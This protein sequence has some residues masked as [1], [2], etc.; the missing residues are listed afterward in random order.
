[1][2]FME[3]ILHL[4]VPSPYPPLTPRVGR[5]NCLREG[6]CS[7][8]INAASLAGVLSHYFFVVYIIPKVR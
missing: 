7:V 8:A 6:L 1:M 3:Y 2:I 4:T 5:Y